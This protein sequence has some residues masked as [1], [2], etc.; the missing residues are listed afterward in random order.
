MFNNN[1]N[2][3]DFPIHVNLSIHIIC[4]INVEIIKKLLS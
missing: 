1:K 3:F 4:S 2:V